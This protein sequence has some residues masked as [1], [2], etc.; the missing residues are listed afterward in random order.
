MRPAVS[1]RSLY[2]TLA[3]DKVSLSFVGLL[4]HEK[5]A[6]SKGS[7]T[8]R[9]LMQLVDI[10]IDS[11]QVQAKDCAMNHKNDSPRPARLTLG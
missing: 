4:W 8:C 7:G 5:T 6:G 9:F 1:N 3:K 11:S 2:N 10:E